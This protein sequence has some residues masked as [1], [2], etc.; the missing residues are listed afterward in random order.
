MSSMHTDLPHFRVLDARVSN[1]YEEW[2][3]LFAA[4]PGREPHSHPAFS[5]VL[6]PADNDPLCAVSQNGEGG[7]FMPFWR[8]RIPEYGHLR[9]APLYDSITPY[10]YGGA[11]RW[12]RESDPSSFWTGFEAWSRES[13]LVEHVTRCSLFADEPSAPPGEIIKSFANVSVLLQ[14]GSE[15]AWSRVEPRLRQQA[16]RAV[17]EGVVVKRIHEAFGLQAFRD[18]YVET[19]N[20]H[21]AEDFFYF[22]LK[23]LDQLARALG[24]GWHLY[25]ASVGTVPVAG[26]IVLLGTRRAYLF[27]AGS[28]ELGRR[29][30][31][32]ALLR[33]VI[34]GS[35]FTSGTHE[36][37]LGGGMG[38][39]D[40]LLRS[41]AAFAPGRTLA[42][43]VKTWTIH[44]TV[45]RLLVEARRASEAN[46]NPSPGF[47]PRYRAPGIEAPE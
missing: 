20:R 13:M 44:P 6:S 27:L 46:W 17:R 38:S 19:M 47:A 30:R 39:D 9:A 3:R 8:R 2:L 14:D 18:L 7:F 4:S 23:Q 33:K 11:Y 37:V 24:K 16:R 41:K 35:L 25:L 10:G 21:G 1:Q 45:E 36:Y 34:F 40:S 26:E 31:A 29:T 5:L 22:S 28:S 42:F 43:R 15:S 12:G 32:N